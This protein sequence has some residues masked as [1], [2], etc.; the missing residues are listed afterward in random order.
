MAFPP[1]LL[2]LRGLFERGR[3]SGRSGGARG[4]GEE[5]GLFPRTRLDWKRLSQKFPVFGGRGRQFPRHFLSSLFVNTLFFS[6]GGGGPSAIRRIGQRFSEWFRI[7]TLDRPPC[8]LL[9]RMHK[10]PL[11]LEDILQVTPLR[12]QNSMMI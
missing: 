10:I 7:Q 9:L 4:G 1:P 6:G 11:F 8:P 12:R 3:L 5:N 2:W